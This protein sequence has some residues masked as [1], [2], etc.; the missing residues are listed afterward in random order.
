MTKDTC[1]QQDTNELTYNSVHTMESTVDCHWYAVQHMRTAAPSV[2][3][4]MQP[5]HPGNTG[6]CTPQKH[7]RKL[8]SEQTPRRL[9][10]QEQHRH[11]PHL[12]LLT[13]AAIPMAKHSQM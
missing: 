6:V 2:L 4:A 5:M 8:W 9:L 13:H 1:K 3:V 10:D 7:Y 12:P 11:Q